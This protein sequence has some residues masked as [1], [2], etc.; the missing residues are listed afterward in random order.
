MVATKFKQKLPEIVFCV[1]LLFTTICFMETTSSNIFFL[2]RNVKCM[3]VKVILAVIL[4]AC[5][6]TMYYLVRHNFVFIGKAMAVIMSIYTAHYILDTLTFRLM[7]AGETS[8]GIFH[9]TYA[10]LSVFTVL[11]MCTVFKLFDK[12]H[13]LNYKRFYDTFLLGFISMFV[14]T[15]VIVYLVGRD[16]FSTQYVVN[17]VPFHGELGS[18]GEGHIA[19]NIVRALGNVFFYSAMALLVIRFVKKRQIFWG[20]AIPFVVSV[21]CETM[22]YVLQC[23]DTDIDDV[24]TNTLGALIGVAVYKLIIEKI[25][26]S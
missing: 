2:S 12:A 18:L 16:Y 21:L 1:A 15:F 23:G 24:I 22:Q 25:L 5:A 4:P 3:L 20:I 8:R 9:T 19:Y 7:Y 10:Y 13:N 26:Q 6:T 11:I 17:F 14:L